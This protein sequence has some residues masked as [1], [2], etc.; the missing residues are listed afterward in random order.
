MWTANVSFYFCLQFLQSSLRLHR[1]I[2]FTKKHHILSNRCRYNEKLTYQQQGKNNEDTGK[3][4]KCNII[5]SNSLQS[6]SLKTNIGKCLFRL[7]NKHFPTGGKF[8]KI[9][10]KNI[11]KRIYSC[12]SNLIP[13]TDG[14]NKRIAENTQP[15]KQDYAAV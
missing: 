8:H 6:K 11:L 3:N 15:P 10:N 4:Q 14:N 1:M 5:W 7:L 9:F 2:Y 13:K 12:K